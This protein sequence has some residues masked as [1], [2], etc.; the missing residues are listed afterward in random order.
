MS[1]ASTFQNTGA[2]LSRNRTPLANGFGNTARWAI[3][4]VLFLFLL[5][6]VITLTEVMAFQN[7]VVALV[8]DADRAR[9]AVLML[10][11]IENNE[12]A[13]PED[14]TLPYAAIAVFL[15][16]IRTA[17]NRLGRFL[18]IKAVQPAPEEEDARQVNDE[19][20]QSERRRLFENLDE[21]R[22]ILAEQE[23]QIA[24]ATHLQQVRAAVESLEGFRVEDDEGD[25]PAIAEGG[26]PLDAQLSE[27][28]ATVE[29]AR[30]EL[31]AALRSE[32]LPEEVATPLQALAD[33]TRKLASALVPPATA[34]GSVAGA[35]VPAAEAAGPDAA[36]EVEDVAAAALLVEQLKGVREG[37]TGLHEAIRLDPLNRELD[38]ELVA[39][40]NAIDVLYEMRH[41]DPAGLKVSVPDRS[42]VE[43]P[44]MPEE[45]RRM[46]EAALE[47]LDRELTTRFGT[48]Y[49]T[50]KRLSNQLNQMRQQS[51]VFAD[52]T[53][54]TYTG[55][56]GEVASGKAAADRY[57]ESL[58]ELGGGFAELERS[59]SRRTR[60]VAVGNVI[61]S[62]VEES[63]EHANAKARA[64][65]HDFYALDRLGF[66]IRPLSTFTAPTSVWAQ[67]G[68]HPQQLAT[69]STVS[70]TT[71]Y[72]FMI[73]AIGSL[74]YIAKQFL[75]EALRGHSLSDPPSRPMSWLL[76][77]PFFGVVVA[78][79]LYL[80]VQAGQLA[81]GTEAE[82]GF[83]TDLNIPIISVVALFAGLLSWQA[84]HAIE[85]RGKAWFGSQTREPLWASGL[86]NALRNE[87]KTVGACAAQVGRSPEQVE[88]WLMYV[89]QVTV[90]MQDRLATWLKRPLDE[91]CSDQKP[92]ERLGGE[93]MW[94]TGLRLAM[95]SQA[96]SLD[97]R[98]LAELL[99]E[100]DERRVRRWMDL[101]LKVSPAMQWKLVDALKVPHHRLF[102][103][104][105]DP[106]PAWRVQ[107]R[108]AMDSQGLTAAVLDHRLQLDD[109][110]R[111]RRWRELEVAVP[112][113]IQDELVEVLAMPAAE[114][115]HYGELGAGFFLWAHD[116]DVALT[117]Q[118]KSEVDLAAAVD[119]DPDW[120]RAWIAR[121]KPVAPATRRRVAAFLGRREDDLFKPYRE[122]LAPGDAQADAAPESGDGTADTPGA[123]EDGDVKAPGPAAGAAGE[124]SGGPEGAGPDQPAAGS[125]SGAVR[126]A[127]SARKS[128]GRSDSS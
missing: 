65:L 126:R 57:Q 62:G 7:R 90:E 118:G 121:A 79:A 103:H 54:T 5:A 89:D 81:F 35:T 48:N 106:A 72:I 85:S 31:E 119:L 59:L 38:T 74:L 26:G 98:G 117:E 61:R 37:F 111:I 18:D 84:L 21:L 58:A 36:T 13:Y 33:S 19:R 112:V 32:E 96:Q 97:A 23:P 101:E 115:F 128:R 71:I 22:R 1:L 50:A 122:Q 11:Q 113:D 40:A 110:L 78:F 87:N 127:R 114:L 24:V 17:Q 8:G 56:G 52:L 14:Q 45:R 116:L 109:A 124:P 104:H 2:F 4:G 20:Y 105:I 51:E 3:I 88:R 25:A 77:R 16:R 80:L 69:L 102:Q 73:G 39:F 91:L 63:E 47:G 34:T 53:P 108:R 6:M 27:M 93:M 123:P 55:A 82:D 95:Q 64:I 10:H 92:A 15:D 66:V 107:L 100:E 76:F 42:S 120:V 28:L 75:G 68:L 125:G 60:V 41:A 94:A 44:A 49:T 46:F 70:I 83:G 99:H 9:S 12:E 86:G 30:G 43:P 29:D 67:I